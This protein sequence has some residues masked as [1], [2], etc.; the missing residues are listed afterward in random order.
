[1]REK[2]MN[3]NGKI[4]TKI[5]LMCFLCMICCGRTV[6]VNAQ[7]D[8]VNEAKQGVVEVYSGFTDDKGVFHKLQN[9]SGFVIQNQ[10][11]SA[12]VITTYNTLKNSEEVKKEYC[13]KHKIA[14]DGYSFNDTVQVVVKGDVTV[15]AAILNESE[16]QNFSILQ[17]E[18]SINE[19]KALKLG[20]A[21]GLTTGDVVYA[22]GFSDDAGENDD[23]VNR[24]TEFSALDVEV[25]E[26]HVQDSGANRDGILHLQHSAVIS[27]GNT[28]GPLL[29]KDG[30]VV[31]L[32]NVVL[33][34]EDFT[35]F[36]SLPIDEIREILDNF[37]IRYDSKEQEASFNDLKKCWQ[38]V[39]RLSAVKNIK[40]NQKKRSVLRL[41]KQR[42]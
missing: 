36:Y 11:D 35:A 2:K 25:V 41:K 32:N 7:P 26:G 34:E 8:P 20:T 10:E 18:E 5:F 16:K 12:F 37:N 1:M 39:S 31:G 6:T 4:I 14:M 42:I 17:I 28:G 23:V 3:K 15:P 24:H 9:A 22:L 33:N 21:E 38:N 13:K 27:E 30:Y 29:N 40:R 19:R